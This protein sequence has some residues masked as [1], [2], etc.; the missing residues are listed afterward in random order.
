MFEKWQI[1]DNICDNYPIGSQT[2][3][4]FVGHEDKTKFLSDILSNKSIISLE[5]DIGVGKTSMG[6]YIRFMKTDHFSP[7]MEIPCK[8]HWNN[9]IFLG[10][11]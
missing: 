7:I 9:D 2:L 6:N 10:I 8:N 4:L 5:G 1:P 11:D 3:D